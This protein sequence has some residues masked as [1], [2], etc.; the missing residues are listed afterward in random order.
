MIVPPAIE[1]SWDS[2]IHKQSN[3]SNSLLIFK[4][5]GNN[6]RNKA[7]DIVASNEIRSNMRRRKM[8]GQRAIGV[9]YNPAYEKY[10]NYVPTILT[11]RYD[12][13]V[14]IDETHALHPLHMPQVK[15]DK[16]EIPETFPTG[17]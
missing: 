2:I 10:G 5:G 7:E 8:R 1:G 6:E 13:F 15:V 11:K 16:E 12:A 14:Y 17:L 3:G 9:V 4:G